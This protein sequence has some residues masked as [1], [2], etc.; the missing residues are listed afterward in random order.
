MIGRLR[1][2]GQLYIDDSLEL[3]PDVQAAIDP[4][5]FSVNIQT[6]ADRD[7]DISL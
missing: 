4:K 6:A 5:D 2:A 7:S 3:G 1:D